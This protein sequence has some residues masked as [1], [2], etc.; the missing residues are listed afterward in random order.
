MNLE[1]EIT[2]LQL[3]SLPSSIATR[4]LKHDDI[5]SLAR[6]GCAEIGGIGQFF[7]SDVRTALTAA[8]FGS[9]VEVARAG[10]IQISIARSQD[11]LFKVR[12]ENGSEIVLAELSLLDPVLDVR[13]KGIEVLSETMLPCW[14]KASY[15][16]TIVK[17]SAL[18]DGEFETVLD[19]LQSIA[20]PAMNRI[21]QKFH[22]GQF[23]A[24]DLIPTDVT[25]YESLLGQVPREGTVHDY[26]ESSLIPH[27]NHLFKKNQIWGLRCTQATGIS[28]LIDAVQAAA[29]I[30]DDQLLEAIQTIGAGVAP[31]SKQVIYN[32]ASIRGTKDDRFSGIAKNAIDTLVQG[33]F[34]DAGKPSNV[35]LLPSLVRLILGHLGQAEYLART[36]PFWRRLAAYSLA[37][38]LLETIDFSKVNIEEMLCWLE[39]RTQ[40]TAAIEILDQ[41]VEPGWRPDVY[42]VDHLFRA[43][44]IL[45]IRWTP[46]GTVFPYDVSD[47]NIELIRHNR[48]EMILSFGVPDPICG[49]RHDRSA[50]GDQFEVEEML[51]GLDKVGEGEKQ[52]T[53]NQIWVA[54][55]HVS[56]IHIF[57]ESLLVR[58][59]EQAKRIDLG[60]RQETEDV[61]ALLSWC[62]DVASTQG[63]LELAEIAAKC[64]LE[65]APEF[66]EPA[67]ALQ[68]AAVIVLASG[69]AA[70]H[71][72]SLKW[73]SNKLLQLAYL[74]PRGPCCEGL[75]ELIWTM[76]EFI[77]LKDRQW[78]KAMCV[79]RSAAS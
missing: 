32:L 66:T 15:W 67:D 68:S 48:K 31:F 78:G 26:I 7:F 59:R 77:S 12:G 50:I 65:S 39:Q 55:A 58:V 16:K 79:A 69:A 5:S 53:E 43:S 19:E 9:Y 75:A 22:S 74:L 44:L 35:D 20:E 25:F 61:P 14:P 3:N 8:E 46:T 51:G 33:T 23:S 70:T 49:I 47:K 18:S 40:K 57:S 56:R 42:G 1:A 21:S 6:V 52:P 54:L 11:A 60:S 73:A 76:E 24:K 38:L 71:S 45:A 30:S 28:N 63:D 17:E 62:C 13:L 72:E 37:N 41:L 2:L 10:K 64:V 36:P 4:L 29:D 34:K 27:L